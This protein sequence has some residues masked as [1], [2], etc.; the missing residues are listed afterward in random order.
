[1]EPL[2]GYSGDLVA[3]TAASDIYILNTN[4]PFRYDAV[5]IALEIE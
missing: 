1:M 5:P 2:L 4:F 3:P